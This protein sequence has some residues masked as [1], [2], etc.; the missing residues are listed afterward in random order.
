MY[1]PASVLPV[2]LYTGVEVYYSTVHYCTVHYCT[3][4][5]CTI[6]PGSFQCSYTQGW[7]YTTLLYTTVLYTTGLE[8]PV[9]TCQAPSS[10]PVDR[11]GGKLLYCTLLYCTLLYWRLLYKHARLLPVTLYRYLTIKPQP[12]PGQIPS[13]SCS[14]R[15]NSASLECEDVDECRE[16]NGGCHHTCVNTQGGLQCRWAGQGQTHGRGDTGNKILNTESKTA[17]D[18]F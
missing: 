15:L 6:L 11:C 1:N 9:Q 8:A 17:L 16:N 2:L 12:V 4:G 10:A 7:R 18:I 5:S 13:L 14:P 3:G